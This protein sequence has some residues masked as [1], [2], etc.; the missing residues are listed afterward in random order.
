M[1]DKCPITIRSRNTASNDLS[2]LV[3]KE[4]LNPSG[5]RGSGAFY[6]LK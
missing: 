6:S 4:L 5:Q 1:S 3:E 2:E